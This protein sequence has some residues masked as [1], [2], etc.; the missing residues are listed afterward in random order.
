[1]DSPEEDF[2]FNFSNSDNKDLLADESMLSADELFVDG[3]VRPLQDDAGILGGNGSPDVERAH[4]GRS[5]EENPRSFS[6]TIESSRGMQGGRGYMSLHNSCCS[7]PSRTMSMPHTRP[8][9]P[10]YSSNLL[11]SSSKVSMVPGR[12]IPSSNGSA[13]KQ[14]SSIPLSSSSD[15]T[16]PSSFTSSRY[17]SKFKDFFK[18]K[19]HNANKDGTTMPSLPSS[20][21]SAEISRESP[22]TS[23]SASCRVSSTRSFW[24]F[25]RS[26]SAG[27]SKT[28]PT[29]SPPP[30]RSNSA[31]ERKTTSALLL[32]ASGIPAKQSSQHIQKSPL[33]AAR[34]NDQV[35]SFAPSGESSSLSASSKK[36]L[37]PL[38]NFNSKRTNSFFVPANC[39]A[40]SVVL[41]SQS[42]H[43]QLYST[44]FKLMESIPN[45]KI[46]EAEPCQPSSNNSSTCMRE[47]NLLLEEKFPNGAVQHRKDAMRGSKKTRIVTSGSPGRPIRRSANGTGVRN[48]ARGSPGRRAVWN[49][50][51][52]G[53]GGRVTIRSLDRGSVS[54]KGHMRPKDLL[55]RDG[56]PVRI[57]PVLNVAVPSLRG[58]K[59]SSKVKMFGFGNIF[60][61]KDRL[62]SSHAYAVLPPGS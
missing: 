48:F 35:K 32:P 45:T 50:P 20:S 28:T 19:R 12:T 10:K 31:G 3:K 11:S 34:I 57:S 8:P 39:G 24:P 16:L 38:P 17:S 26:N 15:G 25:S 27:E 47:S 1:M 4:F 43:S 18:L 59:A 9:S 49:S 2:S 46:G 58:N 30:R 55:S 6:M 61:K 33:F 51:G 44:S 52:R 40:D 53:S 5:I 60:S 14:L 36:G 56:A 37:P 13:G 29:V 42:T 23:G 22:Q 62:S 41:S 21:T 7:S 54:S